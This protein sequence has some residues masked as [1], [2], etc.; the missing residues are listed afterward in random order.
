MIL[1]KLDLRIKT[2]RRR[3]RKRRGGR[4]GGREKE[5]EGGRR[6]KE[7]E[8][9]RRKRRRRRKRN[10]IETSRATHCRGD[11]LHRFRPGNL[12]N[13]QQILQGEKSE[14]RIAI[15]DYL[16]CPIFNNEI[17][18]YETCKET[19]NYDPYLEWGVG[20]AGRKVV[21]RHY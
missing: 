16:K 9:E 1:R 4:G 11:R 15:R 13:K 8:R 19:R 12:L 10:R 21:K 17:M 20:Q 6:E 7:R 14:S 18:N 5:G 2:R 3:R